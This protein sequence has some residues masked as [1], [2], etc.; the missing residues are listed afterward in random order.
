MSDPAIRSHYDKILRAGYESARGDHISG[1]PV[2][3]AQ[4]EEGLRSLLATSEQLTDQLEHSILDAPWLRGPITEIYG[5][6][7]EGADASGVVDLRDLVEPLEKLFGPSRAL[8]IARTETAGAYNGSLAAGL[9]AHGWKSV[10]WIAADDACPDCI[11]LAESSPMSIEE[12][13][14]ESPQHPN[15]LV[16]E[17]RV[18]AS[19]VRAAMRRE[20]SGG[21]VEIETAGGK[22]LSVTP[23]H[24]VLTPSGWAAADLL[25]EGGDV[26]CGLLPEREISRNPDRYDGPTAIREVFES[27]SGSLK[28]PPVTVE[29]SAEDFHG[30]G[31][32]SEVCVVRPDRFLWDALHAALLQQVA[33]A[34]LVRTCVK[35]SR[36]AGPRPAGLH[37]KGILLPSPR[38]LSAQ[39]AALAPLIGRARKNDGG[40]FLD[41]PRPDAVPDEGVVN[42]GSAHA[43]PGS[44]AL[45]RVAAA[46]SA[47]E[48]VKIGRRP[49]LGHVF[50]LSTA[51]GFY[52]AEGILSHNCSC[53]AEPAEAEGEGE[54]DEEEVA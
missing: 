39:H 47:E 35:H 36:L 24:P 31:K 48:I 2:S 23:N 45:L 46:V 3:D 25:V 9:K 11:T 13:E 30:D 6:W 16:G 15:C 32:G 53:T 18:I 33:E 10:N 17:T 34:I 52:V 14:A 21:L 44:E 50:N 42:R 20:Y 1:D 12:F 51:E 22:R 28:M 54:M 29:V 19:G 5:K 38:L 37:A 4:E 40:R 7:M 41:R 26:V 27:P 49:F 8:M 43:V